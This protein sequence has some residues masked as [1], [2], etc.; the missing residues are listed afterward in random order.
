MAYVGAALRQHVAVVLQ[1][2]QLLEEVRVEGVQLGAQVLVLGLHGQQPRPASDAGF[3]V[4]MRRSPL[5][6]LEVY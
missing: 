1:V 3:W 2:L 5:H 6:T 4:T